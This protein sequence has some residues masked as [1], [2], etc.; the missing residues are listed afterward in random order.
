MIDVRRDQ[1]VA[2]EIDRLA[3]VGRR[4]PHISDQHVRQ[5]LESM[6][7]NTLPKRQGLSIIMD[8]GRHGSAKVQVGGVGYHVFY[9]TGSRQLPTL[10]RSLHLRWT[11]GLNGSCR[12]RRSSR[13]SAVAQIRL[14]DQCI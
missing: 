3:I 11:S 14:F 9:D 13:R 2:L 4:H 8:G 6:F 10:R 1:R 12:S 7:P 5:T